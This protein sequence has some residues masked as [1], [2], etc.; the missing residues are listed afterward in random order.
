VSKLAN[1][2][3]GWKNY[4]F[5]N[6]DVEDL[7]NERAHFCAKCPFAVE[8]LV[9]DLIDDDIVDIKGMVCDKCHCPL[10]AKLRS[11]EESCPIGKWHGIGLNRF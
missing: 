3:D 5:E 11:V 1:I 7:A 6:K 8:G 10:S 9:T 2:I 4:L